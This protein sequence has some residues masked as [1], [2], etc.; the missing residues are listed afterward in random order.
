MKIIEAFDVS[1]IYMRDTPFETR[2]L[3]GVTLSIEA[4]EVVSIIGSTGS[5]KSTLVQHFNGL[6]RPTGGKILIDSIDT[7]M[8]SVDL[9]KLRQKVG[10]VFQYP[11]HQLFEET[12]F[13]D[14][15]F[16]PRN[17]GFP[18]DKMEETVGRALEFMELAFEKI[19]DRSPFSL[20]GGEMRRVAFAGVLAM[21]PQ[22]LVLDEPTAGLDPM[23]KSRLLEKLMKL[24]DSQNTTIV[25]VSHAIEEVAEIS[26]RIMVMNEGRLL[27]CGSRDEIFSRSSLLKEAGI[28]VPHYTRLMMEL[29]KR[30]KEVKEN[31]F[32]L[33]EAE[34]EIIR[35]YSASHCQY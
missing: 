16:G 5:G 31:I 32:T 12:V 7:S 9:Q 26:D 2:A 27:S 8:R 22:V 6:L 20:S 15:A 25:I 11:E 1:H 3:A 24:R 18:E 10:L 28:F 35:L 33:E 17:M 14:V 13:A 29:K 21:N 34:K 23:G 19:K 30:G 4:G